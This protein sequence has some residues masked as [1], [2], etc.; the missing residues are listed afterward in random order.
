MAT[1]RVPSALSVASTIILPRSL[2]ISAAGS[3]ACRF[4]AGGVG[5]CGGGWPEHPR[6]WLADPWPDLPRWEI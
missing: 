3:W 2:G 5:D 4:E 6:L 1:T